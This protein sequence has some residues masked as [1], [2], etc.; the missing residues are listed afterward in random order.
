ML[1]T[2][3]N[4]PS[5]KLIDRANRLPLLHNIRDIVWVSILL[6][7]RWSQKFKTLQIMPVWNKINTSWITDLLH[8]LS[9]TSCWPLHMGQSLYVNKFKLNLLSH[10]RSTA[11]QWLPCMLGRVSSPHERDNMA[12]HARHTKLKVLSLKSVLAFQTLM[13]EMLDKWA[14]THKRV[15]SFGKSC[16]ALRHCCL[17]WFHARDNLVVRVYSFGNQWTHSRLLLENVLKT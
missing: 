4:S 17:D 14:T 3:L 11:L 6:H 5:E 12:V 13:P 8:A 16:N 9:I 2:L 1:M 15:Y 7:V 10:E